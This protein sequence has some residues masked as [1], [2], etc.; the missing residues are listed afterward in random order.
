MGKLRR[1]LVRKKNTNEIGSKVLRGS[2]GK[3]E[4]LLVS[5]LNWFKS[6]SCESKNSINLQ[7]RKDKNKRKKSK[8]EIEER[9]EKQQ[10]TNKKNS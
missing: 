5:T 7:V 8:N 1:K 9:D 3:E 6:T 2:K 10:T 4:L